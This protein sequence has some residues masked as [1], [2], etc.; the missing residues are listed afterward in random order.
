MGE[1]CFGEEDRWDSKMWLMGNL[2]GGFL[3]AYYKFMGGLYNFVYNVIYLLNYFYYCYIS[4]YIMR[5]GN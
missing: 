4:G 1:M 5:V 2:M 3:M